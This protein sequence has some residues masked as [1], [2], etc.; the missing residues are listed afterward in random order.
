VSTINGIYSGQQTGDKMPGTET[1]GNNM[2]QD[3]FMKLLSAQLQNQDPMKPQENGEFLAQLAT[4]SSLEKLTAIETSIKELTAAF[5]ALGG[6][7]PT[8][9]DEGSGSGSGDTST[10]N[11]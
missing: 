9:T 4:F 3:A 7:A 2:G 8:G 5:E 10:N 11:S 1:K 6:T